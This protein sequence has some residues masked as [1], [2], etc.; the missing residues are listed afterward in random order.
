[1]ILLVSKVVS[2]IKLQIGIQHM[3]KSP[4]PEQ[5]SNQKLKP[6]AKKGL[7]KPRGARVGGG[8]T[9]FGFSVSLSYSFVSVLVQFSSNST[10]SSVTILVQF[11][12]QFS[13][14]Q[15]SSLI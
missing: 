12:S 4:I 10:F 3:F 5:H 1:M 9:G 15:V 6:Y 13:L 11:Q 2:D 7:K 14:V 8:G